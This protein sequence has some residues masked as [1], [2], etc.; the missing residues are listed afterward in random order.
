MFCLPWSKSRNHSK[1][2]RFSEM[3]Q[4]LAIHNPSANLAKCIFIWIKDIR[5]EFQSFILIFGYLPKYFVRAEMFPSTNFWNSP[6]W[7]TAKANNTDT[8]V[9]V[10]LGIETVVD[11]ECNHRCKILQITNE[12]HWFQ[13]R[14]CITSR[15][16][17]YIPQDVSVTLTMS[18]WS[19][20]TSYLSQT[21][22]TVSV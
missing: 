3:F 14:S 6:V 8:F 20:H 9:K 12:L 2:F 7:Q 15:L 17:Y 10:Y 21:S 18:K 13:R 11:R 22:Q 1:L 16:I 5:K 4:I 19:K